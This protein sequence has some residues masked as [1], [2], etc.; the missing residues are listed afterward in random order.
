MPGKV[1]KVFASEGDE[2]T[3]GQTLVVISAMKM[4]SE[5]K[6]PMDGKIKKVSV[7]EGDT[8]EGNQILIE[9]E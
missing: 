3:E 4:E 2:V 1:V 7:K 8:I 9:L 5:Y 6:A